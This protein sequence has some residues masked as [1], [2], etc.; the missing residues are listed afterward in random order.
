MSHGNEVA[1]SAIERRGVSDGEG[2]ALKRREIR[3]GT[4]FAYLALP[5]QR[6]SSIRPTAYGLDLDTHL[7]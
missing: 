4:L 7:E 5:C 3:A 2:V 1:Y 6:A